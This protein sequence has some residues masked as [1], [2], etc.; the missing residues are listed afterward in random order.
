MN[1]SNLGRRRGKHE[2]TA[3]FDLISAAAQR[4]FWHRMLGPADDEP[5]ERSRESL[6]KIP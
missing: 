4:R 3:P 1:R 2:S 5:I 6:P